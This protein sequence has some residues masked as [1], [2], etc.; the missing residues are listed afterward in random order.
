MRKLFNADG[1][2][3]QVH[4][5]DDDTAA[6]LAGVEVVELFEGSGDD[7]H[8]FGLLKKFKLA[9]KGINLERLGKHFK[10]FTDRVETTSDRLDELLEAITG[11]HERSGKK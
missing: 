9:D 2:L 8:A 7:K 11:E 1:S 3:K 5:L 10:L 4:E 6:G